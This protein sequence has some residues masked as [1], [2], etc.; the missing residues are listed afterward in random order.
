MCLEILLQIAYL[1]CVWKFHETTWLL[2][3]NAREKSIWICLWKILLAWFFFQFS[4]MNFI[5]LVIFVKCCSI[6]RLNVTLKKS[7]GQREKTRTGIIKL[8]M[9]LNSLVLTWNSCIKRNANNYGNIIAVANNMD[10]LRKLF[11]STGIFVRVCWRQFQIWRKWKKLSKRVENTVG[12]GEIAHNEQF[13]LFPQCFQKA[14]F[15][16]ASKGVIMWEWVKRRKKNISF[17]SFERGPEMNTAY[18]TPSKKL[19]DE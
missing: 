5:R 8:F 9:G 11:D 3:K 19:Q 4:R 13:L 16:G 7:C 1:R 2:Y 6:V 17:H 15:P 18:H 14:C 12:K 10:R